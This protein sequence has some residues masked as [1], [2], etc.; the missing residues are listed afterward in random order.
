MDTNS[1]RSHHRCAMQRS[2]VLLLLISAGCSTSGGS[3]T[4]FPNDHK[5]LKSA[6]LV[7]RSTDRFA[8]PRELQKVALQDYYLQ[9]GDV[10][11]L[12]I[13]DLATD[14]RLP[15]DQ[16][17]MPDGS[18][19]LGKYGRPAVAGMTVEQVED[20]VRTLVQIVDNRSEV[21]PINVRLTVAE[22]AVFYVLGEVNA[23]GAYP[24]IGRETVLDALM[25]AGGLS[26]RASNC[27]IILSRPTPAGSCRIVLPVCYSQIVQLGDTTTNYQIQP[28]DR[29][30]VTTR[31]FLEQLMFWR[32]H[33][34]LCPAACA[35]PCPTALAPISPSFAVE[36][37]VSEPENQRADQSSR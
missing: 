5:L 19:D 29:V 18:I 9:P 7:A 28:G 33:C 31:S 35:Y 1:S 16:T 25:T 21:P 8:L 12:E 36:Q 20:V 11:L 2:C 15:V 32:R 26:A 24:L 34:T 3:L 27:E 30:F 17:V 22:S 6:R 14:I 13:D 23:P 4:I 10:V 37:A